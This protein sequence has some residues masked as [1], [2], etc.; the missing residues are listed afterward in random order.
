MPENIIISFEIFIL[1]ILVTI[2]LVRCVSF[3]KSKNATLSSFKSLVYLLILIPIGLLKKIFSTRI[4]NNSFELM[5]KTYNKD[6]LKKPM[7]ICSLF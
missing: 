4:E 1:L 5:D 7:V 6:N 2:L 3:R